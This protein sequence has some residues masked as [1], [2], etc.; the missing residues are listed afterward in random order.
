M[1]T[2]PARLTYKQ[3]LEQK[4]AAQHARPAKAKLSL[5][6]ILVSAGAVVAIIGA[7]FTIMGIM[8]H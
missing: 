8:S 7:A 3:I 5:P 2:K 4:T 6:V 1:T